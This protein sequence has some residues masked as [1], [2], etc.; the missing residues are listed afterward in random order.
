MRVFNHR[1]SGK[2]YFISLLYLLIKDTLHSCLPGNICF[3]TMY[4]HLTLVD[5]FVHVVVLPA[6]APEHVGV[7]VQL[8]EET[9][10]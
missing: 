6:P 7:S 9:K 1:V 2:N 10:F 8:S 4:L 5:A 3:V